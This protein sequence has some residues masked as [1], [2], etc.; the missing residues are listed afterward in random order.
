ME[1]FMICWNRLAGGVGAG[2]LVLLAAPAHAQEADTAGDSIFSFEGKVGTEYTSNIAVA[3]LD[4]NTG[5]GDWA[6]TINGLVEAGGSPVDGLTLR[7]GYEFSQTLHDEFDAFDLALHRGF[8]EAAYD[9]DLVTVGVL[10]NLAQANLD[11]EEYLTF[12]QVSPYISRQFGEFLFVRIS[13]AA[14]DKTF[15]GRP[16]RDA[17]SD[18][19]AADAYFFLDGTKRY[20]AI[21]GKAIEE[22]ATSDELDFSGSSARVRFVQRFDALDR[23]MTFRAGAEYEQRDYDNPTLLIGNPRED[24]RMGVDLSLEAPIADNVFVEGSYRFGDYQSNLATA[25]FDE[26]VTS[27]KLG[28]KY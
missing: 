20:V 7:G 18:T 5:R 1:E 2:A 13:Y 15:E 24:R 8:A 11:G 4:T 27:L 22:D 21:G 26:Q 17:T 10:G 3:D 19:V 14:T 28:V 25:D 6:V 23:E 12:T 16:E 9:F